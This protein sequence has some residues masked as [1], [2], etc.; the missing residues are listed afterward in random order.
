MNW[1]YSCA[2]FPSKRVYEILAG[3]F[4]NRSNAIVEIDANFASSLDIVKF[5]QQPGQCASSASL[6]CGYSN[7]LVEVVAVPSVDG[8]ERPT[9]RD[10]RLD[11]GVHALGTHLHQPRFVVGGDDGTVRVVDANRLEV[12][13]SWH[14]HQSFVKGCVFNRENHDIVASVGNDGMILLEDCRVRFRHRPLIHMYKSGMLNFVDFI[15]E[16]VMCVMVAAGQVQ[17]FDV[18]VQQQELSRAGFFNVYESEWSNLPR[19]VFDDATGTFVKAFVPHKKAS[20]Y[21]HVH[22]IGDQRQLFTASADGAIRSWRVDEEAAADSV[23]AHCF[24]APGISSNV[25]VGV[26]SEQLFVGTKTGELL[27]FDTTRRGAVHRAAAARVHAHRS[28]VVT[29]AL[30]CDESVL[31]SV[32]A[33]RVRFSYTALAP[34]PRYDEMTDDSL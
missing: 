34:P 33:T 5:L 13:H 2:T 11:C 19:S 8:A 26:A 3:R 30:T 28:R 24:E 14:H 32:D 10:L 25:V 17:V 27:S 21:A 6:V 20:T 23:G 12:T 31:A 1:D 18:G 15:S 7:G 9:K 29:L 22:Y 16:H 4:A